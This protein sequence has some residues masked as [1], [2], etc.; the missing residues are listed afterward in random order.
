MTRSA[1]PKP[2][3][4]LPALLCAVAALFPNQLLAQ[5]KPAP[6]PD[7]DP[8]IISSVT[9]TTEVGELGG[10]QYRIDVPTNWNHALVVYFHGYSEGVYTYKAEGPLN[11]QTQPIFD[12][13][14]AII[15]SGY[16]TP[17]WALAEA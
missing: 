15:Q 12:R 17:G 1:H 6:A 9:G 14:Y 3:V 13:G 2:R 10:A 16:S 7:R 5:H 11:E 8:V 4:L